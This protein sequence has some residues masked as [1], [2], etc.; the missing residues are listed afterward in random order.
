MHKCDKIRQVLQPE[1]CPGLQPATPQYSATCKILS[2]GHP[3]NQKIVRACHLQH[4]MSVLVS[5]TG[6]H[7]RPRHTEQISNNQ[8]CTCL[9][10][11]RNRSVGFVP[12]QVGSTGAKWSATVESSQCFLVARQLDVEVYGNAHQVFEVQ[13]CII[14]VDQLQN[15]PPKSPQCNERGTCPIKPSRKG[16]GKKKPSRPYPIRP[17]PTKYGIQ[18]FRIKQASLLHAFYM[19]PAC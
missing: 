18:C 13:I 15:G 2:Q 17:R 12:Q 1:N 9:T 4:S 14:S 11:V 5:A 19:A 10:K 3:I 8:A 6:C 7:P 16:T